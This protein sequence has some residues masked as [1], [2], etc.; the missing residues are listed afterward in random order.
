[1]FTAAAPLLKAN[2]R[3]AAAVNTQDRLIAAGASGEITSGSARDMRE[4]LEFIATLRIQHQ[5][6]QM[7]QGRAPDHH[8]A[9]LELSNFERSNLKQAFHVVQTVQTVLGQ[10]FR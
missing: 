6:R 7:A 10:R 1:M 5:A 3:G 2:S 9:L 8:L 4:A